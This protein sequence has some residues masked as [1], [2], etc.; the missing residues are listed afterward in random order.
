MAMGNVRQSYAN[1]SRRRALH[2][3]NQSGKCPCFTPVGA[4]A[5]RV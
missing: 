2:Q 5:F 3:A 4:E 1:F